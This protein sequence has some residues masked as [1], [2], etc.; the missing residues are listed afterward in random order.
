MKENKEKE[1]ENEKK[2]K[3]GEKGEE[4]DERESEIK[5]ETGS[6]FILIAQKKKI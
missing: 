1:G 6:E 3:D 2:E 4:R 5:K